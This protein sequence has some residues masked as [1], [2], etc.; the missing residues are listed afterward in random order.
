MVVQTKLDIMQQMRQ[1]GATL[2]EIGRRFNISRE[3]VRWLLAKHYGSTGIQGLLTT[4]ELCKLARCTHN[5]IGKLKRRRVIQPANV[6]GHGRMLWQPETIATIILYID[7]HRC[8][9]CHQPLSSG[10]Q[11]YCSWHC[12]H[13]AHRYKNQPEETRKQLHDT[14]SPAAR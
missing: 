14:G 4:P 3:G 13:E 5:Y 7:H 6:I 2:E 1:S 11:V 10:R 9:I 12:Y 8:P